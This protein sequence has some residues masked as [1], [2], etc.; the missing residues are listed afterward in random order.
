MPDI[1]TR[2][3]RPHLELDRLAPPF[4]EQTTRQL[5]EKVYDELRGVAARLMLA[6]RAEH[7]LSATALVNESYL[8]LV[9]AKGDRWDSRAHF[10]S[11][12]AESMRRILIDQARAKN[13]QKRA[14]KRQNINLDQWVEATSIDEHHMWILE[15]DDQIDRLAEEDPEAAEFVKLRVFAGCSITDAGAILGLNKG[16]SYRMWSFVLCWF[17]TDSQ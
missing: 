10:F 15:L 3:I 11:A 2:M 7:T 12:V 1:V 8:R 5:F 14:R 9:A 6:E 17:A 13:T 16:A 4:S